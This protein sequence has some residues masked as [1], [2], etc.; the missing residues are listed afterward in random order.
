MSLSEAKGHSEETQAAFRQA[1]EQAGAPANAVLL[2]GKPR[3]VDPAFYFSPE[4]SR[5]FAMTLRLR[6]G[7]V[8]SP[9][10]PQ[11]V[12]PVFGDVDVESLLAAL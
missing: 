7:V 5:L 10:R 3:S 12:E 4:A 8:C 6:G 11:R 9:P 1:F 2:R